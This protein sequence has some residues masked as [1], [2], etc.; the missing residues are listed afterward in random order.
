MPVTVQTLETDSN[1]RRL[2]IEAR[3]YDDGV[4]FRY[5]IPEQPFVKELKILNEITQFRF[6]K[7]A[8]T[9]PMISR[10]FQT[11]NEDDYHEL[12]INGM[13]PE[14][15]VNLP[16]LI[17]LPGIAWVGTQ[18]TTLKLFRLKSINICTLIIFF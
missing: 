14:Y 3:A 9:F 7:D 13:H 15:L 16:L 8:N 4:A 10:G 18:R 1:G 17:N 6:S 5:F 11:S 12:T 2:I